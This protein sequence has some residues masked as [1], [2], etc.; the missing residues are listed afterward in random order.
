MKN[1]MLSN[2]DFDLPGFLLGE[3]YGN[4]N[5]ED[6]AHWCV[7][8]ADDVAHDLWLDGIEADAMDIYEIVAEFIAQDAA[9]AE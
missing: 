2:Q 3:V 8:D 6:I 4:M 5:D 1:T 9:E 7:D